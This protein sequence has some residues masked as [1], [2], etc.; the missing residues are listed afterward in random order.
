MYNLYAAIS[1]WKDE[2]KSRQNIGYARNHYSKLILTGTSLE[3]G[4]NL[5][6]FLGSMLPQHGQWL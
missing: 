5:H 1:R 4:S 3:G 6:R 2:C